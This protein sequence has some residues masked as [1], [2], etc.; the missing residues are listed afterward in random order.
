M[1]LKEFKQLKK[2]VDL[3]M[4]K[5]HQEAIDAGVPVVSPKYRELKSQLKIKVIE[6]SGISPEEYA[7]MEHNYFSE[8]E[9]GFID[10]VRKSK[11]GQLAKK[12]LGR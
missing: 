2:D 12:L 7:Q 10:D 3:I 1:E 6:E 8:D 9:G 11:I 5:A 4:E